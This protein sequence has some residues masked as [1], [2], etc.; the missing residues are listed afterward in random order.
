[1]L[2]LEGLE[3]AQGSFRLQAALTVEAGA[4]VAVLGASGAGKS[5]LL[6]GIAGFLPPVAGRILWQG[7][8]I[9]ALPPGARPLTVLFQDINLFGNLTVERNVALGI[10]PRLKLRRETRARVAEAL[11]EVGLEGMGARLPH[12]LSGGQQGRVALARALLRARPLLLLDEP[13]S[14][15]GPALKAEM[16]ALI[17]RVLARTGATL[18]MVTHDPEDAR[19]LTPQ[20][21]LVGDGRAEPPR[22]TGELLAA[23]PPALRDWLGGGG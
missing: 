5:T 11:V 3:L 9:S 15:L 12:Q 7:R 23:P 21:I 4:R 17:A 16:R 8:D 1:M 22:P 14:A 20:A 10:D 18:L 6:M 19:A 2:T 13:F